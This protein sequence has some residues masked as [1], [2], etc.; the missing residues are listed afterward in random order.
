MKVLVLAATE[1]EIQ[2]FLSQNTSIDTLIAGVGVPATIYQLQKKLQSKRYDLVIQA[3][4]GGSF[5]EDLYQS[6]AVVAIQSD[7]FADLG[8]SEK[9]HFSTIFDMGFKNEN[10]SPYN[11]GLLVNTNEI[12]VNSTLQ[13]VSA[14][15]VNTV[16]DD[17][18]VN[19]LFVKKY[20]ASVES[21]EGAA[22]HF[23]CLQENIPFL[24]IRAV[25][26]IVGERDK[27]KW[28]MK[29]AITALH[30]ALTELLKTIH[31]EQ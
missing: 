6:T 26:N 11:Q 23:V 2:P 20:A 21:M 22:V 24:Q 30:A 12:L 18:S 27:S 5:G 1:H 13:K 15:T 3:G 29:E 8:I 28:K 4:I 7:A 10:S 17:N 9:K 14:I 31:S 16:T 19:D 25:S